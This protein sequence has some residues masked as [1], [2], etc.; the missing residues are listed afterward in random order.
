M[1]QPDAWTEKYL[2]TIQKKGGS[3]MD[4]RALIT[5]YDITGGVKDFETIPNAKG[6]RI[7]N[8][9]AQS[10]YE[11]KLEG[12]AVES[13]TAT[14]TTGEGF[15]DLLHADDGDST[16]PLLIVPDH[17]RDLYLVSICHTDSESASSAVAASTDGDSTM[18]DTFRNGHFTNVTQ[19]FTDGICKFAITFKAA[20]FDKDAGTNVSFESTDGTAT[21]VIP[22]ITY[23]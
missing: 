17:V 14:G 20:P 22:A 6:G 1:T 5:T 15:F 23:T 8:F 16:Q 11:I 21:K 13:G 9:K 7:K 2:I 18:R 10:D 12:Y 4:F 3:A 19:S